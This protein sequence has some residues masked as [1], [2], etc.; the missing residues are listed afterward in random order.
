MNDKKAKE[1]AMRWIR[2]KRFYSIKD[3]QIQTAM[4]KEW[5]T[6]MQEL[7]TWPVMRKAILHNDCRNIQRF[8]ELAIQIKDKL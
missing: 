1:L 6:R 7:Y 2:D 3:K 8:K 5:C 4:C